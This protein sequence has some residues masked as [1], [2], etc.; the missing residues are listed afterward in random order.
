[1]RLIA[2]ILVF[3][4]LLQIPVF[5]NAQKSISDLDKAYGL[6]PALYN[7]KIYTYFLPYGTGGTQFLFGPEF[8]EGS[9]F[10]RGRTYDNLALNYDVF[11]KQVILQYEPEEG[12]RK[13]IILSDAWLEA[14]NLGKIHFELLAIEDTISRFYQVI[15]DDPYRV[16]Y[17]WR[18]DLTLANQHGATNHVFSEP[19]KEVFLFDGV[20]MLKFRSNKNFIALFDPGDQAA[21]KKYIRQNRINLRKASDQAIDELMNYCGAFTLK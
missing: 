4:S 13:Q 16:L 12:V 14:F 7:G 10:I 1:M 6:D 18:K 2:S 9:A 3:I 8:I 11:N 20:K 21:L 5:V 15:G 17:A 19:I